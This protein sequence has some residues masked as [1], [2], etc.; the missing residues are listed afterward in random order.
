MSKLFQSLASQ[1]KEIRS[2]RKM[3]A[4]QVALIAFKN[5]KQY[6][7]I[8]NFENERRGAKVETLE[9]I[10]AALNCHLVVVPAEKINEVNEVLNK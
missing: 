6:G 1:I 2:F 8:T 3:T 9:K 5:K 10:F 7:R 4:E